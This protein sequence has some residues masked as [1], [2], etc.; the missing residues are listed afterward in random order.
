MM[1]SDAYEIPEEDGALIST[2]GGVYEPRA[3]D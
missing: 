3:C 2:G 1:R